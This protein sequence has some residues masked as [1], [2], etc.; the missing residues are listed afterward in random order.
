MER[1]LHLLVIRNSYSSGILPD[2]CSAKCL[3]LRSD[4]SLLLLVTFLLYADVPG[5]NLVKNFTHYPP[6][7][8]Y[9]DD[10]FKEFLKDFFISPFAFSF[11]TIHSHS[12]F[13]LHSSPP[14]IFFSGHHPLL[15]N[16]LF[17]HTQTLTHSHLHPKT[18]LFPQVL[19]GGGRGTVLGSSEPSVPVVLCFFSP[20]RS[21]SCGA[22]S[23]IHLLR[24]E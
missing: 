21:S 9:S 11:I 5:F 2:L 8:N 10:F 19:I 3:R 23:T 6:P 4:T 12:Y 17:S 13:S 1:V 24:A 16:V 18:T 20:R 7:C 15:K 22:V 14:S